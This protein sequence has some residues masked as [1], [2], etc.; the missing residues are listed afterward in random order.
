MLAAKMRGIVLLGLLLLVYVWA[1]ST[2]LAYER[3]V[4]REHYGVVLPGYI[5]VTLAAGDRYLAANLLV[6]RTLLS[7]PLDELDIKSQSLL[8]GQANVLNPYHADNYYLAAAVLAWSGHLNMTQQ[9][10]TV[11]A[12]Y[13]P[14]D[15]WPLFFKGFNAYYFDRDFSAAGRL[16]EQSAERTTGENKRLLLQIASK[17]YGQGEDLDVAHAI[18]TELSKSVLSAP[19]RRTLDARITRLDG[20]RMLRKAAVIYS[21]DHNGSKLQSL[22]RLVDEAYLP[23]LPEDPFGLGYTLDPS[24]LPIYKSE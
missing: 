4:D 20:L 3:R 16:A 24:G 23:E 18:L 12:D 15:P 13:R 9:I 19:V 7:N 2:L 10:L 8:Q 5:N 17:W 6:I 22:D 1:C 21:E 14:A 11:A